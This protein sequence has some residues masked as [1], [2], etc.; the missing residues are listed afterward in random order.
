M[1]G[2]GFFP[3]WMISI[4][5]QCL[6]EFVAVLFQLLCYARMG[7]YDFFN[8]PLILF[9]TLTVFGFPFLNSNLF[10]LLRFGPWNK[11]SEF[12][13]LG[14]LSQVVCVAFAQILGAAA[15]AG[16]WYNIVGRWKMLGE[17]VD[18]GILY[19]NT[20]VHGAVYNSLDSNVEQEAGLAQFSIFMDE[21]VAQATFLIGLIHIAEVTLPGLLASAAWSTPPQLKPKHTPVPLHFILGVCVLVAGVTRA[22]P[23]A[24]QSPHVSFYLLVTRRLGTEGV[25]VHA[26]WLRIA[27]GVTSLVLALP[28]YWFVYMDRIDDAGWAN[29]LKKVIMDET[30]A[31]MRS[32]LLLPGVFKH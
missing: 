30:P 4:L 9:V 18:N 29:T 15:A 28:Y 23:S 20:S 8:G 22:F 6:K 16:A 3:Q 10:T 32:E 7:N 19:T 31:Y 1:K 14:M 12:S 17:A 21:C 11:S 5:L 2:D 25:D 13:V 27:G 24:H 26:C